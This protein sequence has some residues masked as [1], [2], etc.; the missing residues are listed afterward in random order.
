MLLVVFEN[1]KDLVTLQ[2]QTIKQ[3]LLYLFYMLTE[4]E[5]CPIIGLYHIIT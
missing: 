4:R 3:K 1:K 2:K 5:R